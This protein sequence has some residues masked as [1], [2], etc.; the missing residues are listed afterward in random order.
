ME[1]IHAS[2]IP[3]LTIN[4]L[5]ALPKTPLWDRLAA[6][7]RLTP[8]A[9][10]ESNVVFKLPYETVIGMWRRCITAAYAP[11]ALYARFAHNVAHTFAR[12]KAY[13]SNPQR[14]SAEIDGSAR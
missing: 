5:Y 8:E 11:E 10:R 13:P 3:M 14:A 1:F 2:K 12:R 9:G 6:E 4:V 7:G